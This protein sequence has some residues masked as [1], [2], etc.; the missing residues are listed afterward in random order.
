MQKEMTVAQ[1]EA[2]YPRIC[3]NGVRKTMKTLSS[4]SQSLGQDLNLDL[5]HMK[6]ECYQLHCHTQSLERTFE[7][8]R[9]IHALNATTN[10][11]MTQFSHTLKMLSTKQ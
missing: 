7:N 6:Q 1:F 11:E 10:K 2:I 8:P 5:L 9:Y 4:G 3:L